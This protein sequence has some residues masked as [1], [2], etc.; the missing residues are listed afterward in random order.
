MWVG[1][2]ILLTS[3]N[4]V[5]FKRKALEIKDLE[6]QKLALSHST[7]HQRRRVHRVGL[8]ASNQIFTFFSLLSHL[9]PI[10]SVL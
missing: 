10:N 5:M 7:K 6:E 2:Y 9:T 3:K 1:I 4:Y 8:F